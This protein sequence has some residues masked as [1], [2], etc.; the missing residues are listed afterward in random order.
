MRRLLIPLMLLGSACSDPA[1]PPV[2][3]IA[4]LYSAT[5]FEATAD[6]AHTDFLAAGGY[7]ELALLPSGGVDGQL[8]LP[9]G[10]AGGSALKVNVSGNWQVRGDEVTLDLRP[11]GFLDELRFRAT[12]GSLASDQTVSGVHYEVQL[13]QTAAS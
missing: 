4:G 13:I 2:D 9:G 8:N 11:N 12:A 6:G 3:A 1:A 5:V 7:L 10:G